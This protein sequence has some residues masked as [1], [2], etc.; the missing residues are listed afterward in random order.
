MTIFLASLV[1]G[2]TYIGPM[3]G[4]GTDPWMGTTRVCSICGNPEHDRRRCNSPARYKTQP[5]VDPWADLPYDAHREAQRIVRD[6]PDGMTL[7]EV[8]GVLGV[9]R[10]RI[11]QIEVSAIRKFCA[12]YDPGDEIVIA[13]VVIELDEC[14]GCGLI[15]APQDGDDGVCPMCDECGTCGTYYQVQDEGPGCPTCNPTPVVV[16]EHV[17]APQPVET[18]LPVQEVQATQSD[19]TPIR[20]RK[21]CKPR[22]RQSLP[23]QEKPSTQDVSDGF[24]F[25]FDLSPW[26]F[27]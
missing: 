11:R 9:T 4:M 10:E 1:L 22:D 26:G 21:R 16:V 23:A 19:S 20:R 8:G 5:V 3:G 12:G 7:E 27:G 14:K 17:A 24:V 18:P 13:G 15:F 2:L 6:N 25:A